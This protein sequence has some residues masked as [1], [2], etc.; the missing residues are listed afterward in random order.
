[1][2]LKAFPTFQAAIHLLTFLNNMKA[3][4]VTSSC[5]VIHHSEYQVLIIFNLQVPLMLHANAA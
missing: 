4:L 3:D 1:M 5:C 2:L